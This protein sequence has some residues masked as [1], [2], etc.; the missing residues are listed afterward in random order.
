MTRIS[1]RDSQGR[2]LA[3]AVVA[4]TAAPSEMTDLGYVTDDQG[5]IALTISVA[6]TY[7]FT[8]TSPGGDRLRFSCEL[9]REG[10]VTA[11]AVG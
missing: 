10:K 7:G 3:D 8:L 1:F 6:G 2:P 4:I 9:P 5:G 11:V